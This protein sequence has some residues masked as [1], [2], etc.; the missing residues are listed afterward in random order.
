MYEQ[1]NSMHY[2]SAQDFL[3]KMRESET[4]AHGEFGWL[5]DF[6]TQLSDTQNQRAGELNQWANMDR[7][8]WQNVYQPLE[9]Q[10][11]SDAK[12]WDS[13]DNRMAA[14]GAAT[15]NVAQQMDQADAAAARQLEGYGVKPSDTRFAALNRN[16]KL[17]RATAGA[18]ASDVADR[19]RVMEGTALRTNAAKMGDKTLAA[20]LAEKN[21]ATAT[22]KTAAD[23]RNAPVFG[24][25]D[26]LGN[27]IGYGSLAVGGLNSGVSATSAANQAQLG[28]MKLEEESGGSGMGS[29]LGLAGGIAGSFFGPMGS[30][31]GSALGGLAGRGISGETYEDGGEVPDGPGGG[32]PPVSATGGGGYVDPSMSPSG[33]AETD[34][35]P[36]VSP[37][38]PARLNANEF[39]IPA[40]AT[41]YYGT[42]YFMDLIAKA[43][44]AMG[45]EPQPVG[46]EMEAFARGGPVKPAFTRFRQSSMPPPQRTKMRA[47][48]A[49]RY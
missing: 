21:A 18:A 20:S 43:D 4:W 5:K 26:A 35:V 3:N 13:A 28:R 8:R 32:A 16:A 6:A 1:I 38:G 17:A 7:S 33:G 25:R 2:Q 36:A 37:S 14:R 19:T 9:D 10:I 30:A 23:I 29:L 47:T 41:E 27:P 31:A 22:E 42:K 48:A 39:V 24:F 15:A 40:R 12:N 34:D 45:I 44:K 49:G 11:I 46:P